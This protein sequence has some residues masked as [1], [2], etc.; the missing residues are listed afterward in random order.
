MIKKSLVYIAI[1]AV[2]LAIGLKTA[3]DTPL[4]VNTLTI[5]LNSSHAG[6]TELFYDA[7]EGFHPDLRILSELNEKEVFTDL[8]FLLPQVPLVHLRWD[9]VYNEEGVDTTVKSIKLSFYGGEIVEELTFES[10]VPENHIKTFEIGEKDFKFRVDP[11]FSDP[12][13]IFTKIPETPEKPSRSWV[14]LKGIAFSL[15]AGLL[16]S[17][18]YRLVLWYF[19]G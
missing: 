18:F 8:V 11:G 6:S 17:L 5:E 7:G 2:C 12:Y 16:I 19:R 14:V 13:F 15:L 3:I 1:F 4:G 10:I 9:P